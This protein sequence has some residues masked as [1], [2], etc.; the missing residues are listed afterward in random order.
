MIASACLWKMAQQVSGREEERPRDGRVCCLVTA[1]VPIPPHGL[2]VGRGHEVCIALQR[3]EEEPLEGAGEVRGV[4]MP[5]CQ[6]QCLL[7][8]NIQSGMVDGSRVQHVQPCSRP[9]T[10]ASFQ[11]TLPGF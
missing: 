2:L 9:F 6:S 1:A 10:A 8:R 11:H 4:R 3:G 5:L 7:Q